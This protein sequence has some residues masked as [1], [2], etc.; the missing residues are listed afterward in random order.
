MSERSQKMPR[1]SKIRFTGCKYD[2]FKKEHENSIFDLTKDNKAVHSLFTLCNGGGKGVM[3]QLI[4]QLL[5]PETRWGKTNGNKVISMFFDQRNNLHPFTF[6]VVLE[7]ALD[8]VPA[9]RLITGIAVKAIMKNTGSEEEDKAGL[10]YFLYT[11]EHD[12]TGYYTIEN[13]PLYNEKTGETEDIA[14]VESFINDNKRDFI[15]YSQSGVRRKDSEYYRYLESR[16]IYRSEWINLKTINKSEG[17]AGDY[18]AGAS[19]NKAIFDKI[20]IP[21]ISENISNYTNDNGNSL[22]EMFKSNLSITKDLPVIIEREGAYKELLAQIAPLIENAESGSGFIDIKNRL[23]NEGTDIYFI[24]NEEETATTQEVEKWDNELKK[25][26]EEREELEFKKDN[27]YYNKEEMLLHSKEKE[28]EE[29]AVLFRELEEGIKKNEEDLLLYKINE[30]VYKKKSTEQEINNKKTEKERLIEILDMAD[31]KEKAKAVHSEI[32]KEWNTIKPNWMYTE[33]QYRGYINYTNLTIEENKNTVRKYEH[34]L[35]ELQKE[36]NKFELKEEDLK[37]EKIKLG[38]TY[39]FMSLEFPERIEEDLM[40]IK[41]ST[42]QKISNTSTERETYKKQLLSIK[43]KINQLEHVIQDKKTNIKTLKE[44]IQKKE[45]DELKLARQIANQLLEE[46]DGN[47]LEHHWFNKKLEALENMEQNKNV[48]LEGVQKSIWEKNIDQLLNKEDY[49]IPNKDI[50]AVKNAIQNIGI[51]VETGTEYLQGIDN[52]KREEYTNLYPGFLYSVVIP[53]EREWELI[54]KN[55]NQALFL[56]N[57][58]PIYVRSIM[59]LKHE[60]IFKSLKGKSYDLI[61]KDEFTTWK[62]IIS[63]EIEDFIL[64]ENSLK[65]DLKNIA[66]LKQEIHFINKN[67]TASILNKK[68]KNL[69]REVLDLSE[70]IR[71][72]KEESFNIESK[73][74]I[75]EVNLQDYK[76]QVEQTDRSIEEI[77]RYIEKVKEVKE[78]SKIIVKIKQD[79]AQFKQNSLDIKNKNESIETSQNTVKDS[80]NRWKLTCKDIMERLNAAD[81]QVNYDYQLDTS[82]TN[83]NIPDFSMDHHNLISLINQKNLLSQEISN[84]DSQIGLLDKDIE[85]LNKDLKRY[86]TNL[87]K[88]DEKWHS[89]PYLELPIDEIAIIINEIHK[90]MRELTNQRDK[91]Q[92]ELDH[93]DGSMKMMKKVLEDKKQQIRKEHK[94]APIILLELENISSSINVVEMDIESSIRYFNVCTE[95]LQKNKDQKNR[96]EINL[97]KIKTGYPL[98]LMKGKLNEILSEKIKL[99]SDLVVEDW[100]GKCANNK[101]QIEKTVEEGEKL[102]AKFIKEVNSKLEEDKLKTQIITTIK[103]ALITNFQNNVVSFKSMEKHF[104]NELLVLSQDKDKAQEA[105]KQWTSRSALHIIRMVEALK[106]MVSNMNYMNERGYAF[107]LV[108]LKGIERLPKEVS[109]ITYLLEEYFV[110]AIAKILKMNEEIENIDNKIL[111]DLMG[112]EV[113]FSKALQG[114]YPTLL[115]YKMSEKNEFRYARARDEYYTTW[116]AIN[117][118]EGYLPEGSGGQ[119]LSVNTFVIMMIMSFKKKNISNEN[120]STVL[121]LDNPFGK[122]SA[123]H[124]LDPIFEIADKLN[125]QLIC[126]AAPEIIKVEISERF[127]VFWELK[128]E[129]GKIVH[130]GR[131][132]RV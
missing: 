15:K 49:F 66:K 115:V 118:G 14:K 73:L 64:I 111:K 13:L 127:P 22:I 12:E 23:I 70:Q 116:E 33:N 10:S 43:D 95:E 121:I 21:A 91:V 20:I 24:L 113:I 8:T 110:Q 1:L 103:E 122:A 50:V 83:D 63:S 119:T 77:G 72:K 19:D 25:V 80:Y 125:F 65:N 99:N 108:K 98:D 124:M 57:M 30:I 59:K 37:K 61:S 97:T 45:I 11:H 42:V 74:E 82:Y 68:L 112:D 120:P 126:F 35:E 54:Q 88:L 44:K 9:K 46:Y 90:M 62:N 105:M 40:K 51:H 5:L 109:E 85:Y 16:G 114:R 53:G 4:F 39:D 32:E 69:E 96:L 6:H 107:P 18:F 29:L 89:Y 60:E 87:E 92:S 56:N 28:V 2:G 86:I 106:N 75:V 67:D 7:W 101:N 34:K 36:V 128:I 117:K 79:I 41:D 31:M 3:M 131:I 27:L 132:L 102:R 58:V 26:K 17:G 93:M 130:G 123:R 52:D 71:L 100:L 48:N 55:I 129:N 38:Q 104:Q 94:R 76:E 78:Q 81:K 47:L 84:K